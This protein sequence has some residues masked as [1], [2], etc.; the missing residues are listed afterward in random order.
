MAFNKRIFYQRLNFLSNK[1]RSILLVVNLRRKRKYGECIQDS[2]HFTLSKCN[3]D[4][5]SIGPNR[6]MIDLFSY[7]RFVSRLLHIIDSERW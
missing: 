7:S 4:F 2:S 6:Q 3:H 1:R 5:D